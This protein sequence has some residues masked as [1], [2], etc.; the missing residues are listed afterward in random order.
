M[1]LHASTYILRMQLKGI[2]NAVNIHVGSMHDKHVISNKTQHAAATNMNNAVLLFP[3]TQ[4]L[5]KISPY[6]LKLVN[7]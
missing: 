4:K 6:R 1:Y 5:T 2:F 3:R 7:V